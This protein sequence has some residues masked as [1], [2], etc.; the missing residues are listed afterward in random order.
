MSRPML[1]LNHENY[2][3]SKKWMLRCDACGV[4]LRGDESL[5]GMGEIGA[6]IARAEASEEG[7]WSDE[8]GCDLCPDHSKTTSS[9]EAG[10]IEGGASRAIT[11]RSVEDH[12]PLRWQ[13][14]WLPPP[15][16]PAVPWLSVP[17][18]PRVGRCQSGR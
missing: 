11:W 3:P 1:E 16:A 4:K 7:W 9:L 5:R 13:P 6:A 18:S 2:E 8:H 15:P 17:E 14:G 12:Q 10:S